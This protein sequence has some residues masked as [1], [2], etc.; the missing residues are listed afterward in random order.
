MQHKDE[1]LQDKVSSHNYIPRKTKLTLISE[2]VSIPILL[3]LVA[4]LIQ[5]GVYKERIAALCIDVAELRTAF[6]KQTSK[7]DGQYFQLRADLEDTKQSL[8]AYTGRRIN[9]LGG[10]TP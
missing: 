3:L 4:Q 2:W 1:P 5:V 8:C 7:T 9:G 10:R 6:E